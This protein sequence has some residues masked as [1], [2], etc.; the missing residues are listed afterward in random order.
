VG[1]N[2]RKSIIWQ[3]VTLTKLFI[4]LFCNSKE[5]KICKLKLKQNIS[6]IF[7]LEWFISTCSFIMS[8]NI[9]HTVIMQKLS[10]ILQRNEQ[11]G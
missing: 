11:F 8:H 9:S 7:D 6:L 2:E 10:T 4:L 3:P 5:N 1:S